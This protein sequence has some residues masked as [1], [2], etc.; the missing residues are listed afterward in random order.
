M[1]E[2]LRAM[3]RKG[4]IRPEHVEA[5]GKAFF[6]RGKYVGIDEAYVDATL[7]R[8][9]GRTLGKLYVALEK[10]ERAGIVSSNYPNAR[11]NMRHYRIK[12]EWVPRIKA[13]LKAVRT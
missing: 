13:Y 12:P 2:F 4:S 6:R 5:L 1:P 3:I 11:M 7:G 9:K 10:G 8:T